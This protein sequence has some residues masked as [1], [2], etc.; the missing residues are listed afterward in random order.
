MPPF[1]NMATSTNVIVRDQMIPQILIPYD[2]REVM[3]LKQAAAR[4]V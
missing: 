3:T 1:E 4:G 2:P